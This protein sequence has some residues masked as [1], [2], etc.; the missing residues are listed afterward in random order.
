MG[1]FFW[2]YFWTQIPGKIRHLGMLCSD[3]YS[4]LWPVVENIK[5]I[6]YCLVANNVMFRKHSKY[7]ENNY[8]LK[9]NLVHIS[10]KIIDIFA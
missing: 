4:D 8:A 9:T 10:F 3:A 5:S 6:V 7:I 1:A 2:G